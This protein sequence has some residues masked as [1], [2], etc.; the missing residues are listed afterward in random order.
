MGDKIM[1]KSIFQIPKRPE[2]SDHGADRDMSSGERCRLARE[3]HDWV[4]NGVSLAL[5]QLD[6]Y[7]I[8]QAREDPAAD[9]NL[10]EARQ[11]LQ[12]L[13]GDVRRLVSGLRE[14]RRITSLPAALE[15]FVARA[16]LLA[17]PTTVQV[18][19]DEARLPA[20]VRDELFLV[21]REA[22]RNAF[23]H[24]QAGQ[25]DVAIEI[26]MTCVRVRV[27]DDGVGFD[28]RRAGSRGGGMASMRERIGLLGGSITVAARRPSGTRVDLVIGLPGKDAGR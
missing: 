23:A 12:E 2:E 4:G 1:Q 24:G 3:L 8:S 27:E 6:L 11:T 28:T 7:A 15:D 5:R 19:G 16:N 22:L 13:L 21:V 10:V 17:V 26:T 9:R 20:R 18:R 14:P 25:V